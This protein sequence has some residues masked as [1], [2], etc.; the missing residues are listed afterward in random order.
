MAIEDQLQCSNV[1]ATVPL[2]VWRKTWVHQSACTSVEAFRLVRL[3]LSSIV[4]GVF[5][6]PVVLPAPLL[7]L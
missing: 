6:T 1:L 4:Y 2:P 7:N 5:S 3:L